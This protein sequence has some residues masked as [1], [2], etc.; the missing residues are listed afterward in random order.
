MAGFCRQVPDYAW[1]KYIKSSIV[2]KYKLCSVNKKNKW[3]ENKDQM[4]DNSYPDHHLA[5]NFGW[6]LTMAA[7]M[8]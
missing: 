3:N 8:S 6:S 4:P 5:A 7:T 2:Q 1:Y